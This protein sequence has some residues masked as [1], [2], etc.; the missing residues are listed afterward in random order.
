MLIA[1]ARGFVGARDLLRQWVTRTIQARY[2]QS[3]LGWLWVVIQ[4]IV[5][6][7]I[8]ALVFTRIVSV[9]T[10]PIPYLAFSYIGTVAWAFL[11]S[12]LTDM[13]SA[14]VDNMNLVNKIYF[15]RE[16]LPIASMLAR[17]IDFAVAFALFVGLAIY[18]QL[19]LLSPALVFLP[20]VL[21]VQ[22]LL[23]SGIG[24]LCAA[25]NVF[26][27]DVRSLLILA[28]Q[29]WFYASPVIY[30]TTAVPSTML[31]YYTVNPMVGIIE[32]Y[33]AVLLHGRPPDTS[34][35]VAAGLSALVFVVGYVQFKRAEHKFADLM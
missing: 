9:D 19:P 23:V 17:L 32:G 18:Y 28:T 30:P 25:G 31:P 6:T 33:R 22:V 14:L 10:G 34:F 5:Q 8:L 15:P 13:T 21:L 12:S 1:Q 27:R 3:L 29:T 26:V 35:L 2:Q 24:L 16:I 4:P 7:L 11:A 20:A